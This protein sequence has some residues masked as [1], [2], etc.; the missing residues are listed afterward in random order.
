MNTI[1]IIVVVLLFPASYTGS[2][3]VVIT[4]NDGEELYFK[5]FEE[6]LAH[7]NYEDHGKKLYDYAMKVYKDSEVKPIQGK[8]ILC[9]PNKK[10]NIKI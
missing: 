2:D 5:T 8:N 10:D 7:V 1:W 4:H 6:C 3:G 9:I